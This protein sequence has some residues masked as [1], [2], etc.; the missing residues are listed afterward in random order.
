MHSRASQF[1][2][3]FSCCAQ[4]RVGK[5]TGQLDQRV[6]NERLERWVFI[7]MSEVVMDLGCKV[8][9]VFVIDPALWVLGISGVRLRFQPVGPAFACPLAIKSDGLLQ[10]C[11]RFGME[12]YILVLTR[13]LH[14]I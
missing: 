1:Q 11:S 2:Q 13:S 10:F 8:S 6:P 12:L 4:S 5:Q 14:F 3:W 7:F 9:Q